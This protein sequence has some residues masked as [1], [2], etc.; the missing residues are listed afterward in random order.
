MSSEEIVTIPTPEVKIAMVNLTKVHAILVARVSNIFAKLPGEEIEISFTTSTHPGNP[1]V[2]EQ[3]IDLLL[4]EWALSFGMTLQKLTA[5]VDV[6]L[7]KEKQ[8]GNYV[9]P[10]KSCLCDI[11]LAVRCH[12]GVIK[13]SLGSHLY[14]GWG[15]IDID[16][17][18]ITLTC[19][20]FPYDI[21]RALERNIEEY[22]DK[23][24][25]ALGW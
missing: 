23:I 1:L 4:R 15:M 9:S 5:L 3:E 22:V 6:E 21:L 10:V 25:H 7:P 14:P 24:L 18:G 12:D 2:N 20:D 8:T 11:A 13:P 17:R 16:L 19:V